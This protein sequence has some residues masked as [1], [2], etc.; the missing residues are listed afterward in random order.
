LTGVWPKGRRLFGRR[1]SPWPVL[2]EHITNHAEIS[3]WF[4]VASVE[5][6]A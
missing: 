2:A 3:K 1:Y 5:L 4:W 6:G